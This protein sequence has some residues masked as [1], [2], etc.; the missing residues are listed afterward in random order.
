MCRFWGLWTWFFLLSLRAFCLLM[1]TSECD[2]PP[3]VLLSLFLHISTK[4][5]DLLFVS[6]FWLV[7]KFTVWGSLCVWFSLFLLLHAYLPCC[8]RP[9]PYFPI[10]DNSWPH[11]RMLIPFITYWEF[12][13]PYTQKTYI[14]RSL[15]TATAERGV[16][17][18]AKD[19]VDDT[20][21]VYVMV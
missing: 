21:D 2:S 9:H 5:I 1:I 13:R 15:S 17:A 6:V 18:E 14:S 11:T 12:S 10:R 19:T 4:L 20:V 8:I 16:D 7:I 3:C